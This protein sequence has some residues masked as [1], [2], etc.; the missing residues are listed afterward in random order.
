MSLLEKIKREKPVTNNWLSALPKK[1]Q[2]ELQELK[3]WVHSEEYDGR[4]ITQV[5]ELA[6]SSLKE[7]GIE[8]GISSD[9]FRRW[10]RSRS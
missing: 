10:I 8:I 9:N 7:R 6:C 2:G 4:T 1:V 3:A 5:Y